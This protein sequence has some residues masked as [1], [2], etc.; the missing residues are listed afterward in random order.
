VAKKSDAL[1]RLAALIERI[2]NPPA[3]ADGCD[4]GMKACT[5]PESLRKSC[6]KKSALSR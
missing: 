1:E 6:C 3:F 4:N 5:F 2:L